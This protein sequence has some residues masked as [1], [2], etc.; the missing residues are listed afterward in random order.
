MNGFDFTLTDHSALKILDTS[1]DAMFLVDSQGRISYANNRVT[2]LFGYEPA[3]LSDEMVEKLVPEAG[4]S[5][6]VADREAYMD[7]P[8]T[9]PMGA[10]VD[11][12]ARR[13]DGTTFPVDIS[14]S[15]IELDGDLYVIAV[16]RD[17]TEQEAL[18]AKYKTIL[19]AVPDPVVVADATTGAIVEANEQI[20]DLL[21]YELMELRGES[22]TLLH[23]SDNSDRYRDLFEQYIVSDQAIIT[24]FPDGSDLYLESKDG[25]QLPVEI[26]GTVFDLGDQQLTVRVFRDVTSRKE[27]EAALEGL[28]TATRDLMTAT[29]QQEVASI[30][31]ETATQILDL[32]LSGVHLYDPTADALVPVAWSDQLGAMFAGSPP[33][34]HRGDGVAWNAF[35]ESEPKIY[36]DLREV[37]DVLSNVTTFLSELHLPL[38]EHGVM[39]L[40]STTAN[41]FDATDEALARILADTVEA[42]LDR[43]QHEHQLETQNEQ[44]EEFASTVSHDLRNPLNVANGRLELLRS[45]TESEH[46]VPIVNALD[47]MERIIGDVLWLAREGKDIGSTESIDLLQAL[48]SSWMMATDDHEEIE[49]V[50]ADDKCRTWGIHADYDRFRQLLENLFRNALDHGGAEV[51]V[52]VGTLADGLYVEDDGPGIPPEVRDTVFDTGYSTAEDGTGFGLSIV[53]RVVDAHGWE[54]DI[55]DSSSG[56]ARFE[57]TGVRSASN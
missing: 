37:D 25:R 44:L 40:S 54:I 22:Q 49:L 19:E 9:R 14:L 30:A 43:V 18:R 8:D 56:G 6:H 1:P 55:T 21:G 4:R 47:R 35:E 15:P 24:Q 53:K 11:L 39:L 52:T 34:L 10:G 23:P 28:H 2:V 50:V 51:T 13:K 20:V 36:P 7:N 32:P 3:E 29:S 12:A 42:A 57:I 16:V 38:G 27:H 45:E 17:T 26:N 31:S 46:I 41:D 5:A 48:E 33:V